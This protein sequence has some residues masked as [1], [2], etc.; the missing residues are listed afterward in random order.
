[1]LKEYGY[2]YEGYDINAAANHIKLIKKNFNREEYILKNM[3]ALEKYSFN[4]KIYLDFFN[5]NIKKIQSYNIT[6]DES[7][8]NIENLNNKL[9]IE[10]S[11]SKWTREDIKSDPIKDYYI[12]RDSIVKYNRKKI[13]AMAGT[14]GFNSLHDHK[15]ENYGLTVNGYLQN[16]I[17]IKIPNIIDHSEIDIYSFVISVDDVK[18]N[19]MKEKI[20][21][22][23]I[24]PK[25]IKFNANDDE[26]NKLYKLCLN[27]INLWKKAQEMNLDGALFFEDD[28]VFTKNWKSILN[29]FIYKY[30]PDIVRMDNLPYRLLPNNEEK[31]IIFYKSLFGS[32]MGGYYLSKK[33]IDHCI[34]KIQNINL[35][36]KT[37]EDIFCYIT[38][39]MEDNMYSSVPN[40]CIQDWYKHSDS[41]L[42]SKDHM[43]KL[44]NMQKEVYFPLYRDYYDLD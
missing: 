35:I 40:L 5:Q 4:N 8:C 17:I 20:G 3:K 44:K 36:G 24:C 28:I 6:G 12:L 33:A 26:N 37:I 13:W 30:K 32:C 42:Q 18:K 29:Y 9:T 21:G 19:L 16:E 41:M 31:N 43:E 39:E 25:A 34:K 1:M 14:Y 22:I 23:T 11:N 27:H 2:Y 38:Q 7:Y 15:Y 10:E